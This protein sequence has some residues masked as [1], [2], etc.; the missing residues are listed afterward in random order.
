MRNA[1]RVNVCR[2]NPQKKFNSTRNLTLPEVF[3]GKEEVVQDKA[4]AEV[5]AMR[6]QELVLELEVSEYN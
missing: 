2:L 5:D 4:E 3:Q 6:D 1:F